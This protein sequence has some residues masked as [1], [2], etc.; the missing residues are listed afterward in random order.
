MKK[1]LTFLMV[2][3]LAG[4]SALAAP[5]TPQEA[6]NRLEGNSM[7]PPATRGAQAPVLKKT[8]NT[9]KGEPAL[10]VFNNSDDKGFMVVSAD[11]ATLP[12][13]GFSDET[14]FDENN[15]PPALQYWLGEYQRQIEYAKE[16]GAPAYVPS[17]SIELPDYWVPIP[18]RVQ[19]QWNQDTPYNL[20][21]PS[22][23]GALTYTGCVATS[24]AQVMKYY[25]YPAKGQGSITYKSETIGKTLSLDFSQLNFN[26]NEMLYSYRGNYSEDQATA[27]ATLMMAAG[28]AVR[29]NYS[30]ATSG[31]VSGY[32]PGA[33]VQYFGYDP[34]AYYLSRNQATYTD[35]ATKIYNNLSYLG[36]VIYDGDSPAQG[37]HSFICD[38]YR[39]EGYFHF[40]W[41][42][43]G[44][45]DGYFML[46][47][48]DPSG[49]GIGGATGGFNFEQDVVLNLQPKKEG[50]TTP[51]QD[52]IALAGS[53]R[54]K[55]S[56]NYLYVET[57][58]DVNPGL[59]YYGNTSMSFSIGVIMTPENDPNSP[60]Y[61]MV[62]NPSAFNYYMPL[63]PGYI[64]LCNGLAGR[65][66]P[67]FSLSKLGI[68]DNVKY[69]VTLAYQPDGSDQWLPVTTGVGFTNSFYMT[70]SGKE[71]V[72]ENATL[73]QFTCNELSP[74]GTLYDVN[75]S[76][77]NISLTNNTDIQ[78]TR[79]ATLL[80][81]DASGNVV[82]QGESFVTS[83]NPGESFAK[84]WTTVMNTNSSGIKNN[85]SLYP[86]LL[87]IDTDDVYYKAEVPVTMEPN[88]GNP[89]YTVSLTIN[90]EDYRNG[91][92]QVFDS[93]SFMTTTTVNVT[94]GLFTYPVS[95]YVLEQESTSGN[96]ARLKIL[97][98]FY[99]PIAVIENG[100]KMDMPMEISFPNAV[101][102]NQYYLGVAVNYQFDQDTLIGFIPLSTNAGI[103]SI[104]AGEGE[105]IYLY[106]R[107]AQSLKVVGGENG[108]A[109][110]EAYY[111]NGMKA[112][113]K[114]ALNGDQ[115]VVD[116]SGLGKGVVVVTSTDNNGNRKST[117]L[118]L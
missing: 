111:L 70:K 66:Y 24:M 100:T 103:D 36:P 80:L 22:V 18:P 112:P 21:C 40:N 31:A 34:S 113:V 23:N 77:W 85:I 106:D 73:P 51:E 91:N 14:S 32:V 55:T 93:S 81:Y 59:R 1:T 49:I 69:K 16:C 54:G 89:T 29:M 96:Q 53:V 60:I 79:G 72:F 44:V 92:Y 104:V 117:K 10:Y 56:G 19:T 75:A 114:V 41:G 15:I 39:G 45:S 43:G 86:A 84:V 8:L 118:A 63:D 64:I 50:S 94:K 7:L 6:L 5:L 4:G 27:V 17:R 97:N 65:P 61:K 76:Q 68:S 101:V 82:Y 30:T 108:I 102:G 47:A 62:D 74:V 42:W 37:G 12:L 13:L 90:D 116:L 87:D 20:L 3:L 67:M 38:G 58:G 48:L 83:L 28:Y 26:Y 25:E 88:P 52:E 35:W 110:V 99:Q 71:Y 95:V 109:N 33:L 98:T 2:T 78:L 9:L 11:D 57:Y 105:I 107:G 115:A 46:D